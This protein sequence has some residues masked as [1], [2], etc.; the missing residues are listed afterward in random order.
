MREN[1]FT[2]EIPDFDY[3]KKQIKCQQTCPVRT[4]ARG[5]VRAIAAE[6]FELAYL[7]ARGPNPLASIC[8]SICGS[9][10]ELACR[11]GHYD[12]PVAIR[13]LKRYVCER[14]GPAAQPN[15]REDLIGFLR[16]ASRQ[17]A[18]RQ[19]QGR[20][21][22]LP[23]LQSL[24]SARI[25]RVNGKSVGIIGGGPAGLVAAHDLA[26]LGFSVTIYEKESVLGGML[27]ADIPGYHLPRDLVRA[28]VDVILSLGV[29]AV[30]NCCVGRDIMFAELRKRHD[31][32]IIAMGSK[33]S[34]KALVPDS[35]AQGVFD[36]VEF[37]R[38][39]RSQKLLI[40]AV[41]SGKAVARVLYEKLT[42]HQITA[43]DIELHFPL[44][45]YARELGYE[46]QARFDPSSKPVNAGLT[47]LDRSVE[48]DYS[49]KQALCEAGR[50][51][52]CGTNTIF[53]SE[54][55]IFCGA[56]E[57]VCPENCLKLVSAESLHGNA[58]FKQL[59]K[60][61]FGDLSF[62]KGGAI[63]KRDMDETICIRCGLCAKRCPVGA[64]TM[65]A[66][67][68][69]EVFTGVSTDPLILEDSDK[70]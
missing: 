11:R 35:D 21:E 9:P 26:L 42:G 3:W 10:C 61:H 50:C 57:D 38:E 15:V 67:N 40:Q 47:N 28:E 68:F 24:T 51:L 31:A 62:L 18:P 19:C 12:E 20:E 56:C 45:P 5:Y 39:A 13:A 60:N 30:T 58:D 64:I 66:F 65:E 6:Q 22:L 53:D 1:K 29:N 17:Y 36:G 49:I 55:C 41:A 44:S 2:I 34:R 63:I 4:D 16:K 54:K 46:K 27:M 48:Q 23:F 43:E 70:S 33:R 32:I 69:Q 8:G 52:D 59:M 25:P 7:I 37:L 14:F